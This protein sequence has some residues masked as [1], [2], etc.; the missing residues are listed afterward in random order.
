MGSLR[1]SHFL[2]LH[3]GLGGGCVVLIELNAKC[4]EVTLLALNECHVDELGP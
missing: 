1:A 4:C 3:D 2:H